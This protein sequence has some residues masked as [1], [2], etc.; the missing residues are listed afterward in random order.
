M[1]DLRSS[2]IRIRICSSKRRTSNRRR[3]PRKTRPHHR[4]QGRK[5][6]CK[7]RGSPPSNAS[8]TSHRLGRASRWQQAVRQKGHLVQLRACSS[9]RQHRIQRQ[10]KSLRPLQPAWSLG[11]VNASSKPRLPRFLY[12]FDKDF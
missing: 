4:K 11:V 7:N 9:F 6:F 12:T 10:P 8:G 3:S 2:K 1:S 5:S